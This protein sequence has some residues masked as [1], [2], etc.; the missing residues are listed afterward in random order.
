MTTETAKTETRQYRIEGIVTTRWYSDR[1]AA[2]QAYN[3]N[4]ACNETPA[5]H[6]PGDVCGDAHEMDNSAIHGVRDGHATVTL[7]IR[8]A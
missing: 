4:R 1:Y 5:I 2:T 3:R 8:S 6:C 7:R